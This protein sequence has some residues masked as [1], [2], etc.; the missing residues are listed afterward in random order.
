MPEIKD[1]VL[2]EWK[3][4]PPSDPDSLF[5]PSHDELDAFI[6][7]KYS[8]RFDLDDIHNDA[9]TKIGTVLIKDFVKE[10]SAVKLAELLN[11][12]KLR[13]HV[14]WAYPQIREVSQQEA[15]EAS[16]ADHGRSRN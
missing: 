4:F 8:G 12:K 14:V 3:L 7:S 15:D 6:K 9:T 11:A 1:R 16:R 10:I 2:L 13:S 5:M